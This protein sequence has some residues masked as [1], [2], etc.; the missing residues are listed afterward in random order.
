MAV[1]PVY[2]GVSYHGCSYGGDSDASQSVTISSIVTPAILSSSQPTLYIIHAE[3]YED[4]KKFSNIYMLIG[5]VIL[6][7]SAA[8]WMV[9]LGRDTDRRLDSVA[10]V[11]IMIGGLFIGRGLG[12]LLALRLEP[13]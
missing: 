3:K 2:G 7:V 9:A 8:G 10:M 6:V 12:Q 4:L 11:G 1:V 5:L 13:K